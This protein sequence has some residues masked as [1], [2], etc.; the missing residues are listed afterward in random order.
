MSGHQSD[1]QNNVDNV[2]N[3]VKAAVDQL[4]QMGENVTAAS[5]NGQ[6]VLYGEGQQQPPQPI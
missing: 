1:D 6:D 5:V 4:R 2:K 3:V